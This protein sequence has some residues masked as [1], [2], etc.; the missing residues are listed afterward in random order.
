MPSRGWCQGPDVLRLAAALASPAPLRSEPL[1]ADSWGAPKPRWRRHVSSGCSGSS[2]G[3]CRHVTCPLSPGG[4]LLDDVWRARFEAGRGTVVKENVPRSWA[5]T[6]GGQ[7]L[8]THCAVSRTT[9]AHMH[10]HTLARS[11]WGGW[12]AGEHTE[13][14]G[15]Q[16]QRDCATCPLPHRLPGQAVSWR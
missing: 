8:H 1:K 4:H 12:A 15:E 13:E 3:G 7:A 10:T 2:L 6:L 11:E 5:G 9:R 16:D 14:E